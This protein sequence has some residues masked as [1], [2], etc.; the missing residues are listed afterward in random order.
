MAYPGFGFF[1]V[2]C[3]VRSA[4][5]IFS[6]LAPVWESLLLRTCPICSSWK[7]VIAGDEKVS[8]YL[9]DDDFAVHNP[10]LRLA[11]AWECWKAH[12]ADPQYNVRRLAAGDALASELSN[13]GLVHDASILY[14]A[15]DARPACDATIEIE[16]ETRSPGDAIEPAQNDAPPAHLRRAPPP[17]SVGMVLRDKATGLLLK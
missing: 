7:N 9:R 11:L 6:H 13:N 17:P 1:H 3:L 12:A 8:D 14:E 16:K 5:G 15:I 4:V 10:Q 2:S